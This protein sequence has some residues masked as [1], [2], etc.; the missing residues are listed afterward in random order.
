MISNHP[1][2]NPELFIPTKQIKN[3]RGGNKYGYNFFHFSVVQYILFQ[4]LLGSNFYVIANDIGWQEVLEEMSFI[5]V[6]PVNEVIKTR[7]IIVKAKKINGNLIIFPEGGAKNQ[8]V[9][10]SGF[11]YIAKKL[12]ISHLVVAIMSPIPSLFKENFLKIIAIINIKKTRLK[13]TELTEKLRIFI[14]E[15][16]KKKIF[17]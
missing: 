10:Q 6:N 3:I 5:V 17:L 7:N 2:T 12:N 16:L 4:E 11:L 13:P 15:S 9:F 8:E 14:I 1:L